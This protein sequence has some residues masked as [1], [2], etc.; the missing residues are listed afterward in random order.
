MQSSFRPVA[1][2]LPLSD[3]AAL[4]QATAATLLHRC[5]GLRFAFAFRLRLRA[6]AGNAL[7]DWD[8][9]RAVPSQRLPQVSD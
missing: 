8:E 1:I 5:L 3:V 6:V 7:V 2:R 4:A 9:V